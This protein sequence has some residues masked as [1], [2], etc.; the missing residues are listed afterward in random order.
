MDI[1]RAEMVMRSQGLINV[2]YNGMP[3]QIENIQG[4]EAEIKFIGVE[5]KVKI[6]VSALAEA[7][8]FYNL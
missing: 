6:P 7:D 4:D 8:P 2:S 5:G 1:K 3:V